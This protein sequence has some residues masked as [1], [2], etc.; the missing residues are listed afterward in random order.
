M[1]D[2]GDEPAKLFTV[3]KSGDKC[4]LVKLI[5]SEN[6]NPSAYDMTNGQGHDFT[7]DFQS[8]YP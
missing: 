5:K 6:V 8:D 2:V 1:T 4:A 7:T 3:C